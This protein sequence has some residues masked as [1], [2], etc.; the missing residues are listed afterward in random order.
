MRTLFMSRPA[1]FENLRRVASTTLPTKWGI[2]Q[3]L[4]FQRIVCNGVRR[5]ETAVVLAF[6]E[7]KGD[8]PLLR[9][10]SQCLTGDVLGSLRCD[11]GDQ[12]EFAMRGIAHEHRGLL[13]YE[14]QEGR[15]IGLMAKLQ[16]YA[17][18]DKGLDTV[19]ANEA[20]GLPIDHRDYSLPVAILQYLGIERVRLLTNNPDKC[21]ALECAGIYVVEK[22]ACE[23]AP[24]PN[25]IAYLKAKREKLGHTLQLCISEEDYC[26]FTR[27]RDL[28]SFRR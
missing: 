6:G 14:Q 5:I 18:Q 12:L 22:I 3:A 17:L 7:L 15:G 23:A 1:Q 19:E 11:C 20:L 24:N 8:A 27:G 10:H 28:A 25:S 4:G 26:D 9:I 13:I 2:F 21:R 16:A